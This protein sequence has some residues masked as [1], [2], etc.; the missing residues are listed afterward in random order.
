M[1]KVIALLLVGTILTVSL[2]GCSKVRDFM[3]GS[4]IDELF[5]EAT[6]TKDT[7][8][9]NGPLVPADTTA[10][11][12][13]PGVGNWGEDTSTPD[14]STPDTSTPDTD[15]GSTDTGSEGTDTGGDDG[16]APLIKLGDKELNSGY[17][18]NSS[19]QKGAFC[20]FT[21]SLE[22]GYYYVRWNIDPSVGENTS[23]Y[24]PTMSSNGVMQPYFVIYTDFEEDIG[25]DDYDTGTRVSA[26]DIYTLCDNNKI[27]NEAS[28]FEIKNDGDVFVLRLFMFDYNSQTDIDSE[29]AEAKTFV[30]SIE[31]YY[32]TLK[33]E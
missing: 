29:V 6:D 28:F 22:A 27:P 10:K 7:G 17:I 9:G 4:W 20:Y 32:A 31:I 25:Q 23:P 30:N 24:V 11:D 8:S 16:I 14:T 2:C 3:A 1:K 18:T 13:T 19:M 12:T 5:S 15:S 33:T 21:D 26:P